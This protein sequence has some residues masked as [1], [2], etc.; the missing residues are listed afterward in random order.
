MKSI[1]LNNA[2]TS[3]PKAPQVGDT[4]A[5]CING[6][7]LSCRDVLVL[8]DQIFPESAVAYWLG[9]FR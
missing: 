5:A 9:C 8:T 3:W 1:Y 4:V 2:A 6:T 7:A